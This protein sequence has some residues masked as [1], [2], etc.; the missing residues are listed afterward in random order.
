[1]KALL[2]VAKHYVC[3]ARAEA[4]ALA[5]LIRF[6]LCPVPG[7]AALEA[8]RVLVPAHAAL[9]VQLFLPEDLRRWE[10]SRRLRMW[11]H[12][13]EWGVRQGS[14]RDTAAPHLHHARRA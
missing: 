12:G 6:M 11:A 3:I 8:H 9:C 4:A 5:P 1:M 10:E 13:M 7:S 14:R 2:R